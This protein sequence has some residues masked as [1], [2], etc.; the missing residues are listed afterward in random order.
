MSKNKIVMNNFNER[1]IT[2][3]IKAETERIALF[4][5]QHENKDFCLAGVSHLT[6][7]LLKIK[8]SDSEYRTFVIV[9][10]P[11]FKRIV[12]DREYLKTL[13]QFPDAFGH[14]DDWAIVS[15]L[16]KTTNSAFP[17]DYTDEQYLEY[18]SN[19]GMA[20]VFEITGTDEISDKILRLDLCRGIIGNKF[21]G[22]FFHVLKHFT[23]EGY[24]SISHNKGQYLL[25]IWTQ[26]YSNLISNFFSNNF[27]KE[28]GN[29]TDY[30]SK[31]E[32]KDGRILRGV[33]YKE[34]GVPVYFVK[35]MRI[36][37]R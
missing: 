23:I 8:V 30:I 11:V 5:M 27:V 9:P 21:R 29:E 2:D 4:L 34:E 18:L 12:L 6:W 33:Y 25:E 3:K 15:A 24:D 32:L 35:S 31:S 16:R 36:D 13:D 37:K 14:A 28:E 1:T 10:S 26:T 20:Y 22:G 19:E 17:E 7:R